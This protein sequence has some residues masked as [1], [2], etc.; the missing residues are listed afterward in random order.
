MLKE[1][2]VIMEIG[3]MEKREKIMGG[4]WIFE[5]G[6]IKMKNEWKINKKIERMDVEMLVKSFKI[7]KKEIKLIK[8]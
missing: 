5:L 4:I 1:K 6:G 2:V 8:E 7:R 3:V